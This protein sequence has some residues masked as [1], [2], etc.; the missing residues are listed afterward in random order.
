MLACHSVTASESVGTTGKMPV[1]L[2]PLLSS[3]VLKPLTDIAPESETFHRAGKAL[4]A[5]ISCLPGAQTSCCWER[6]P[7]PAHCFLLSAFCLPPS[8]FCLL[9]SAF[10]LLPTAFGFFW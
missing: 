3:G 7:A 8:A 4:G 10:C 9:S 2:R 5:Q 6:L 1:Q